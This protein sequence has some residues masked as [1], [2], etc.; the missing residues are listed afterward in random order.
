VKRFV[1]VSTEAVLLDG[2]PLVQ[3]DEQR[4]LPAHAIGAYAETKN[5]A[6]RAVFDQRSE[7]EVVVVR[8]R[9]IWGKGDTTLLPKLVEMVKS[10]RF[11][12]IGGGQ[13]LTSTCHVDNVCEG[14]H[15]AARKG[16]N[17]GIYFLTDGGT[18][19]VRDFLSALIRTQGV[20]PGARSMP[21]GLAMFLGR[22]IEAVWRLLGLKSHPPLQRTSVLLIGQEVT[23]NDA[24]ARAELGYVAHVSRDEGLRELTSSAASPSP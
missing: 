9:F 14:I 15:L 19:S 4:P 18:V 17:G 23:V 11:A 16:E 21:Y 5:L 22:V 20:T 13:A 6:E 10:G 2:S 24:R 1:H 8:P 12:W 3:V 7:L